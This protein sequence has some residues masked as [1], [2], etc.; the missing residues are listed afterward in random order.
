MDEKN[1]ADVKCEEQVNVSA[2]KILDKEEGNGNRRRR[3]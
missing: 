2:K 1:L 3:G